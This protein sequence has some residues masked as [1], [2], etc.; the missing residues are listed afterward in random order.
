MKSYSTTSKIFVFLLITGCLLFVNNSKAQSKNDIIINNQWAANTLKVD[1]KL[2]EWGDSLQNF[3]ENTGFS[4]NLKNNQGML[5]L[6]IKSHNKQNLNRII[7]RGISFSFNTEGKKKQGETLIF[8]VF[9]RVSTPK[10]PVKPV[11]GPEQTRQEYDQLLSRISRLFITGFSD[12]KDGPISLNNTYGISAAAGFDEQ[13]NL[14][15]EVAVPFEQL[16]IT[17]KATQLACLIEINGIKQVRSTYDPNRNSRNNRYGYPNRD[18]G[19]DR[20]PAVD[21]QLLATGFWI[22][23]SLAKQPESLK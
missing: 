8:P 19:Y 5:Y 17:N 7:A 20:R 15:I 18:Y 23:S 10:K 22:K 1:G 2:D 21:K 16:Q 9:D 12:I 3:N 14:T 4:Y 13:G 11:S 6:A